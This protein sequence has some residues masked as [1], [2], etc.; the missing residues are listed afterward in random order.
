MTLEIRLA[1]R[2]W[3]YMTPLALGE[4]S[5]PRLEVKLERLQSLPDSLSDETPYNAFETSFSRH[6]SAVEAGNH[7]NTAVPQFLM[8]GFRHQCIIT[9]KD[10][11]LT[12]IDSLRGKRIGVTGWRDSGNVWT[13]LI[14]RSKGINTDDAKWYAGRLTQAHPIQDR[15]D[16]F[17]RPGVIEAMP[18]EEP[19]MD[20]LERGWLDAVFTPFM[21]KGFFEKDSKFRHLLSDLSGSQADYFNTVGYVP[22][23]H[24]LT[25]STALLE[26]NPWAAQELSDLLDKSREVWMQ[27]RIRYADTTPFFMSDLIETANLLPSGWGDSG[28]EANQKM[29]CDFIDEMYDQAIL[30]RHI[31]ID[32]V[33]PSK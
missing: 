24:I 33:F 32:E 6:L 4:I 1:A 22:G 31:K 23:I 5:S 19:M 16:G 17:G 29:I 3:D 30:G 20:A 18:E 25:M 8:R 9:R 21:P 12:T 7:K 2:D 26:E 10:S 13:R 28:I 14:L 15:L 27:K 11:P